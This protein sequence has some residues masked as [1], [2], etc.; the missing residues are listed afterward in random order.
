LDVSIAE[1]LKSDFSVTVD[2]SAVSSKRFESLDNN[3]SFTAEST[4]KS[5]QNFFEFTLDCISAKLQREDNF[6]T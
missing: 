5:L 6:L 2:L 4:D 3:S 1:K